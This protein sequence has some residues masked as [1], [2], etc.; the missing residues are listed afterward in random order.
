MYGY[1]RF[2]EFAQRNFAW[3]LVA[4]VYITIVLTA[5]QVGLAT[6]RL[7]KNDRFQDASYGFTVFSILTSLIAVIIIILI[8]LGLFIFN[9]VTTISF[10]RRRERHRERLV[11][12]KISQTP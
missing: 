7:G 1:N 12:R 8:L 2:S 4:F 11:E 3:L 9:I 6:D 5:M 10:K